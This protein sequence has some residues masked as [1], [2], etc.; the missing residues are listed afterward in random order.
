MLVDMW[1]VTFLIQV[2]QERELLPVKKFESEILEAISQNP[3][4]I[5]RGATGC[6]KT[7]Q[8]PQFILDDCIQNDRAAECNI[9]VTQVRNKPVYEACACCESIWEVE[10]HLEAGAFLVLWSASL[11]SDI[12]VWKW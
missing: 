6:G 7:T 10:A 4:V 9:V 12:K 8:V 1:S 11:C 5:I 3:V 2:L